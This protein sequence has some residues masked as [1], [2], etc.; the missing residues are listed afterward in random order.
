MN[1]YEPIHT[2]FIR[3]CKA[4][5]YGI[6]DYEDLVNESVTRAFEG[7]D[8]LKDKDAFP[9]YLYGISK[10]I[11]KNELRK[12][13]STQKYDLYKIDSEVLTE[14]HAEQ[15]FE[16]EILY[17]ALAQIPEKQKEA[18]ILFEITGYSIK[19]ISKIQS[20]S[21]SAVKQRLKRGRAQL[22]KIICKKDNLSKEKAFELEKL[23][24]ST[25]AIL[26]LISLYSQSI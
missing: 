19:E 14:N 20:S 1:L 26:L 11:I 17:K 15:K 4:K 22:A 6:I 23:S 12:K 24:E 18:I 8:K 9:A 3:Y 7:F 16:I 13:T 25:P 2:G 5:S 10:N 21:E